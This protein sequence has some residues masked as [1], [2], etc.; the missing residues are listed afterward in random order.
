MSHRPHPSLR[1]AVLAAVAAGAVLLPSTTAL[2]STASDAAPK[3]SVTAAGRTPAAARGV[4]STRPTRVA[5]PSAVPRGRVA[6]GNRPS[7]A[8]SA[9]PKRGSAEPR[10]GVAAGEQPTA[11][12]SDRTT[13]LAGS[14]AAAAVLAGAGALVLRRRRS[15]A[16]RNG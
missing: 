12:T 1:T 15:A 5:T 9:P 2:A 14:A 4:D 11:A 6:A 16:H 13:A 10:G 7:P 3:P 8:P